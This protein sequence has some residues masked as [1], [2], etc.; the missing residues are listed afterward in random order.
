MRD[1][2][3][4][5][6]GDK[7]MKS[8]VPVREADKRILL[9]YKQL[10]A[11]DALKAT[12]D[13]PDEA[14]Y[15]ERVRVTLEKRGVYLRFA[16]KLVRDPDDP[17]RRFYDPRTI[18]VWLSLG[19][20]GDTI[21]TTGGQLTREAILGA[22]VFGA[23][24]YRNVDQG[25]VQSALD[26]EVRRLTTNI[27]AG[28]Q[29]HQ[30]LAKIRRDAFVGVA[31][32]SD[33]FGGADFPDQSIWD[34]PYRFV[35]KALQMNVG[36]NVKASQAYLVT[37]AVLTRNA[38]HRLAQYIDDSSS[39][40]ERAVKVLKVAKTAGEVA[41]VGL[42]VFG[43]AGLVRGGMAIAG[44][45]GGAGAAR[46]ATSVDEAAERLVKKYVAENPEIAG[47]LN[48][49]RWV[50]GPPGSVAGG[51]KPGT[52]SGAGTGFSKW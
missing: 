13:N 5:R 7:I 47:D 2:A 51:V 50:K 23:G 32:V 22:T 9:D 16:P 29:Q 33:L 19:P 21:P 48:N 17:S 24:Y 30:A 15:L 35:L 11:P 31:E 39:G 52:S 40:A 37:A 38:G 25:K 14:A 49:V 36:G 27:E 43:V 18:E 12:T 4:D 41:E 46:A 26:K 10:L 42:A 34:Q 8:Y 20:D 44:E 1:A 45:A 28:L 3:L 6:R